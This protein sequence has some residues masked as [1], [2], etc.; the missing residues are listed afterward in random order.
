MVFY[1]HMVLSVMFSNIGYASAAEST[2]Y[3][4]QICIDLRYVDT[5]TNHLTGAL[6]RF[7]IACGHD[8]A[9]ACPKTSSALVLR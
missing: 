5:S 6:Q 9:A 8:S 7:E 3:H 1:S 2:E 4:E